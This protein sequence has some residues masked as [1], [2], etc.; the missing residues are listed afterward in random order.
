M[1]LRSLALAVTTVL[2]LAACSVGPDYRPATPAQLNVPDLWSVPA[3]QQAREDLTRWWNR[4]DDPMLARLVEQAQRA[5]L[6]VAQAAA[7]LRI[8]R[9]S[10]IQ[11]RASLLPSLTSS[12]S[13]SHSEPLKGGTATTR[14]SDGTVTSIGQGGTTSYSLGF[15]ASYQ[16]DLF[17][18]VSRS[19][20]VSRASY[21]ASGFTYAATLLSIESE[22]ARN[23]V[24]ARLYQAQIA[25]ARASLAIQDDNLQ[26]AEWRVQAGLVSSL[27]AETARTQRATTAATIPTLE[28]NYNSAVSRIGVLTGQAPGALKDELA[29]TAPI[30]KGPD[31]VGIGIPAE[32]LRQRPDV[33]SAERSLA[34]ATAQVGVATA[35][36]YPSLSITGSLTTNASAFRTLGDTITGQLFGSL[37]QTIF[38]GGR[39]RSQ[40]RSARASADEAFASYKQTV[41]TALEDTENAVVSLASA[42]ERS[43]QY[44]IA[45]DSA[46]ISAIL[47]RSQYQSGLTDF[48]TLSTAESTLLTARNNLAQAQS[49]RATALIQLYVALGGGWDSAA[50]TPSVETVRAAAAAPTTSQDR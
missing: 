3:E 30:P 11:S 14:L 7:R 8:A 26:I 34:S 13:V 23:Y 25:N 37:T 33:R 2:P 17:G 16:V 6:D 45:L 22:L 47:S 27:D 38:D 19:I 42:E 43:R 9:E 39:L 36:L 20:A 10:L 49:D 4:F 21:E 18:S 12:G 46:N 29:A 48:T 28:A 35:A 15:D 1:R 32:T 31:T 24:L 40:L 41:L 5:N 50:P 44:A